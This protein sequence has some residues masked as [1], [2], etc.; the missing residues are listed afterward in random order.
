MTRKQ[1]AQTPL[2]SALD[3][4]HSRGDHVAV[5]ISNKLGSI[6]FLVVCV[7]FFIFW[8]TLNLGFI[9]ALQPFDKYPFP[10]LEMVVSI[11]AIILSVSVLISQNRQGR[12][13]KLRQ[14]VEFEVNVHAE[15]EI[16][17][18]LSML[19]DIQKK[20]GIHK[21]DQELEHMK[22]ELDLQQ[23]HERLDEQE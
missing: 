16:T 15:T 10:A 4:K 17:K 5:F 22:E 12:L 8:I 18:V 19:H 2:R 1:K 21:Q 3:D 23:L 7:C 13:E 14:Q 20:L 11:F 9:P 6:T